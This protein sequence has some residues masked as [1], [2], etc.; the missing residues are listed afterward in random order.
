MIFKNQLVFNKIGLFTEVRFYTE[1]IGWVWIGYERNLFDP[2]VPLRWKNRTQQ[3]TMG[4]PRGYR[5]DRT[6]NKEWRMRRGCRCDD[7]RLKSPPAPTVSRQRKPAGHR[8][9]TIRF[10]RTITPLT[11]RG[12]IKLLVIRVHSRFSFGFKGHC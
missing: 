2:P 8:I 12:K 9:Q 7:H 11:I 10:Q 6:R 3:N 5:T 4:H 1:S